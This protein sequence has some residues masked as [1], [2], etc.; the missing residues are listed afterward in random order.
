MNHET[1]NQTHKTTMNLTLECQETRIT[2]TGAG[3][4][5]KT[6]Y[7]RRMMFSREGSGVV[8]GNELTFRFEVPKGLPQTVPVGNLR[9]EWRV[10]AET[11][12]GDGDGRRH[13][14]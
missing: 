4:N 8:Q 5:R 9:Y 10:I 11:V 12:D 1:T 3:N 2:R 14:S 13:G 6:R 7:D